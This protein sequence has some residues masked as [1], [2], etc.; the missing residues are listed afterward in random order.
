M[1]KFALPGWMSENRI[2]L[3]N[4]G[5]LVGTTA[6]TSGLG[7]AYWWLAARLFPT[8]T[9]GIASSAVSAMMFLS[10]VG[11]LGLDT[12]LIGE[13][14]RR[15]NHTG[16]LITGSLLIT[17]TT[18]GLLGTLF[19]A[20]APLLSPELSVLAHSTGS[21]IVFALGVALNTLAMIADQALIG[22]L[23]GELQLWR[24]GIFSLIKLIAL[25]I[26]LFGFVDRNPLVIYAT[27]LFGNAVSLA[28]L[29]QLLKFQGR[30]ITWG[31][32][33][34]LM[35]SHIRV[36]LNHFVLNLSLRAPSLI[37]PIVTTVILSATTS[38]AFFVAWMIA[39]LAFVVP[40]HLS[41][42]LYAV[43]A[44][45]PQILA[46]KLRMTLRI[47]FIAAVISTCTLWLGA[48]PILHLFGGSYAQ[49]ASWS[50]RL[51]GL[52]IFPLIIRVHFVAINRVYRQITQA[53]RLILAG[54]LLSI[55]LA[56]IGAANSGL[57]GLTLG[58]LFGAAIEAFIASLTVFRAAAIKKPVPVSQAMQSR[59]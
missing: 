37:L 33:W 9:V 39:N 48:D 21:I 49:Q 56:A 11:M 18:A 57:I 27:W 26:A 47:S 44:K 7:F 14:S 30:H 40:A 54:S 19:A 32:N 28:I 22:L 29:Y 20:A 58:W 34:Q 15:P 41:T 24:N 43:S 42:T 50:L 35:R 31:V 53:T 1:N 45:E 3:W 52:G 2:L 16:Q 36:S 23:W 8:T 10:T 4:A 46:E 38:A 51:I 59:P 17:G 25:G 55:A 12:L 13:L 5:S 6:L